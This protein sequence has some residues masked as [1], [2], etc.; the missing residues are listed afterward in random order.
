MWSLAESENTQ[1]VSEF[2]ARFP[3][4]RVELAKRM[5][6][7]RGLRLN[8]PPSLDAPAM[9]RFNPTSVPSAPPSRAPYLLAAALVLISVSAL[10][11]T[12]S[13]TLVR[14][15]IVLAPPQPVN[16]TP[17]EVATQNPP[18]AATQPT[19]PRFPESTTPPVEPTPKPER[20]AQKPPRWSINQIVKM[21]Q[22]PLLTVA[23]L[24][25]AQGGL[26]LEIA[27]K[28]PNP[29][30]QVDYDGVNAVDIL[31]D[32]GHTYSFTP[33]LNDDDSVLLVPAVD[34]AEHTDDK[35]TSFIHR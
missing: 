20:V 6:M 35:G 28:M 2:D 34:P 30:I 14:K 26:S 33:M 18:V 1:A 27:P 3:E 15:P 16:L 32:L 10:G 11:Y 24:V 17:I 7:V 31:K 23:K 8:R 12:L 29:L 21:R 5:G 13:T 9:P 25:A 4:Y 19:A 22:V